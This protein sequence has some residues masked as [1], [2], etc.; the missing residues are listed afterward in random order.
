[1]ASEIEDT[2]KR[3]TAHKG[4]IAAVVYNDSGIPIR[5]APAMDSA[6]ATLYPALFADLVEKSQQMIKK[7]D[8]TNDFQT[9]RIRSAKNEILVYPE[10]NYTLVVV[11]SADAVK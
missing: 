1:M 7:L 6:Q 4:V 10:K 3:L 2:M 11:Q 9:M 5:T 8:P